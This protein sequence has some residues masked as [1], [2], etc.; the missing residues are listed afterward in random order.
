VHLPADAVKFWFKHTGKNTGNWF[1]NSAG[2]F[3]VL[4]GYMVWSLVSCI[5]FLPDGG[6]VL[7]DS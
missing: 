7:F 6:S 2:F 4:V 3:I 5:F 1:T